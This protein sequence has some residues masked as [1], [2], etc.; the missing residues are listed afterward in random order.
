MRHRSSV[1]T[2]IRHW[3]KS[4]PT[5][6]PGVSRGVSFETLGPHLK[7]HWPAIR[8]Q[9]LERSYKPQP[10]RRGEIPKATGTPVRLVLPHGP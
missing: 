5:R 1:P 10:V 6:E 9:L 3:R 4:G 7:E 2:P 8:A